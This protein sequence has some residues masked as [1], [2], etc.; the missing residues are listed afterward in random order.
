M[1]MPVICTLSTFDYIQPL[2]VCFSGLRLR[3]G[4]QQTWWKS[5][6][7]LRWSLARDMITS[8]RYYVNSIDYPCESMSG[9]KWYVWFCQLLSRQAPLYLA[10][11]CCLVSDSTRRS[12]W[13]ADVPTCLVPR[14]RSS[15]CD[16]TFTAAGPRLRNSLPVQ[17]CN[18]DITYGL[19]RRQLRDIFF[20][21]HERGALWLLICSALE[22]HLLTFSVTWNGCMWLQECVYL[23]AVQSCWSYVTFRRQR[24][25]KST[26][27]WKAL[28]IR[29]ACCPARLFIL[30]HCRG[31]HRWTEWFTSHLPWPRHVVLLASQTALRE[32]LHMTGLLLLLL[33]LLL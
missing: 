22:K 11:D 28:S 14:T 5:D 9:S 20:G 23:G 16:R 21:K 7:S 29:W 31:K 6:T 19:L 30:T 1:N 17:L 4:C 25:P 32:L 27:R 33:L 26:W 15:Y 2:V 3:R 8:R 13:S 12:L 18:P 10:D 24:K